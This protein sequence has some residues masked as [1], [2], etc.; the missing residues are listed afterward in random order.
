METMQT[1]TV[2]RG[3]YKQ[4]KLDNGQIRHEKTCEIETPYILEIIDKNTLRIND[5]CYK[6]EDCS[7][8]A[9]KIMKTKLKAIG[10]A[11]GLFKFLI[12]E[13][14]DTWEKK[15]IENCK[16]FNLTYTQ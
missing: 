2:I 11:V 16:P 3:I 15:I 14:L 4:I 10:G 6:V 13:E 5:D 9:I 8:Y 12:K 7:H 1:K